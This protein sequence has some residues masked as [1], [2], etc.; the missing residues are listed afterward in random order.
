MYVHGR[1]YNVCVYYTGV[2]YT[3]MYMYNVCMCVLYRYVH[4]HV[5]VHVCMCVLYR[6]VLGTLK[7]HE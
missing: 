1:M 6:Y 4:V 2:H 5:H 7:G 3:C